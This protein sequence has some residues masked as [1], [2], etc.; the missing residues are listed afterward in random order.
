MNNILSFQQCNTCTTLL[1]K[2][3][4]GNCSVRKEESLFEAETLIE[5]KNKVA[6]KWGTNQTTM[7]KF[8]F[9]KGFVPVL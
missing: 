4:I 3:R 9:G 6:H 7:N 1:K 8:F 5:G 2:Y